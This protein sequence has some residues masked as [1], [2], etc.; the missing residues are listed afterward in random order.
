[1]LCQKFQFMS[2]LSIFLVILCK[3]SL[4]CTVLIN[5]IDSQHPE[6]IKTELRSSLQP[7]LEKNFKAIKV[8]VLKPFGNIETEGAPKVN[9]FYE[10]FTIFKWVREI[11]GDEFVLMVDAQGFLPEWKRD[12]VY[13]KLFADAIRELN[14]LW[15]EE[16]VRPFDVDSVDM[17]RDFRV[18]NDSRN[19]ER[20]MERDQEMNKLEKSSTSIELKVT[21]CEHL[22]GV[23][24]YTLV[25]LKCHILG[26]NSVFGQEK[27]ILTL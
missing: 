20:N 18:W 26:E 22:V 13:T 4:Y 10:D 2:F 17:Y 8:Y 12:S 1:M 6:T 25:F 21:G 9:K 5:H 16:P 7:V 11:V 3:T 19:E 24:Q 14:Y 15:I 27:F 23:D